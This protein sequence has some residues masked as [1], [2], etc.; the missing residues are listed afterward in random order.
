MFRIDGCFWMNNEK[1]RILCIMVFHNKINAVPLQ[2]PESA[3][4]GF[5]MITVTQFCLI[6]VDTCLMCSEKLFKQINL[7]LLY[8][9]PPLNVDVPLVFKVKLKEKGFACIKS[10]E[11]LQLQN[12]CTVSCK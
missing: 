12:F 9:S 1:T 10:W 6:N 4:E 3:Y 11:V 5:W 8:R 7:Q 2:R